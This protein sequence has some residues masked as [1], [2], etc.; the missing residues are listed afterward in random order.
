M[1]RLLCLALLAAGIFAAT[2][3]AGSFPDGP[4]GPMIAVIDK[5]TTV[6]QSELQAD[7]PALQQYLGQVCQAWHCTGTLYLASRRA[8]ARD[9]QI[10]VEDTAPVSLGAGVEGYHGDARGV[11]FAHVYAATTESFGDVWSVTFTHELAEMLADPL[12][13]VMTQVANAFMESPS[14]TFYM[15]EI[16]DPVEARSYAIAGVRMSDFAYRSWFDPTAPGPYDALRDVTRP[17]QILPG[18]FIAE[19]ANDHWSDVTNPSPASGVLIRR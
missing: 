11:P 8:R 6:S 19:F 12:A 5:S 10:L 15:L 14:P 1:K 3:A 9:W 16:G 18:G 2:A 17:L 13:N 4:N 7:L